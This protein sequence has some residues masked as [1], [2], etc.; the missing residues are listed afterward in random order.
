MKSDY[1]DLEK[2]A[3][4]KEDENWKFRGFLKFYDEMSDEEIDS[5]VFKIA[6][7]VSTAIDCTHC[8]RCCS[9]LTPIC[10]EHDQQRVKSTSDCSQRR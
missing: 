8:G 3:E 9:K 5:L 2:L 6:D 1:S 10:S 7:E 4:E